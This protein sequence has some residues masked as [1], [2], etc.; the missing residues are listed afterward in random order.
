MHSATVPRPARCTWRR[1]GDQFRGPADQEERAR[2]RDDQRAAVL[3]ALA[4]Y[5]P[6]AMAVFGVEFG[7]TS[8]QHVLP[9]GGQITIDGPARRIV[10]HF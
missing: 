8:P 9:Y 6:Q 4:A 5:H 3:R 7:H 1:E 10:A 2:F